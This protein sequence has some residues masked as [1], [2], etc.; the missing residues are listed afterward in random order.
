MCG[1]ESGFAGRFGDL[2]GALS[3]VVDSVEEI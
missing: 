2:L 1:S 3:V